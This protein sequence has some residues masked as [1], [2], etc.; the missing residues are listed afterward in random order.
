MKRFAAEAAPTERKRTVGAALAANLLLAMLAN[1]AHAQQLATAPFKPDSGSVSIRCG[2][3]IDGVSDEPRSNQVVVIVDGRF[4]SIGSASAEVDLDL[5]EYTCLPGLIDTHTHI[6][7]PADTADLSIFYT[8]TDEVIAEA[9][10]ANAEF[11]LAAGSGVLIR[12][13]TVVTGPRF[14][15]FQGAAPD[16]ANGNF[17][18]RSRS[19]RRLPPPPTRRWHS[20]LSCAW[21]GAWRSPPRWSPRATGSGCPG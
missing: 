18:A 6:A 1:T 9:A 13:S 4:S 17:V 16:S 15:A 12:N 10:R 7:E 21:P 14:D 3:L 20:R 11:T 8:I 2:G 19:A 5:S